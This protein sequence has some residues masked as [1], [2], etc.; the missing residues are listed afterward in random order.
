MAQPFGI[1]IKMA[2]WI[3]VLVIENAVL[4]QLF[5]IVGKA[6]PH[7]I[8]YSVALPCSVSPCKN[9]IHCCAVS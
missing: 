1:Q 4:D 9:P 5:R 8:L 6:I 2:V 3:G 7:C